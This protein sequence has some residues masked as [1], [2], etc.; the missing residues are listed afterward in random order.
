MLA[1]VTAAGEPRCAPVGALFVR[2]RWYVPTTAGSSRA[3][4]LAARPALSLSLAG[5]DSF[6]PA[7]PAPAAGP[8]DPARRS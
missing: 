7:D 6:A 5:D 2:G 1:T 3:R 8:T 4:T